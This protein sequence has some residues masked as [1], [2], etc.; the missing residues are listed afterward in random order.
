MNDVKNNEEQKKQDF[1]KEER[2]T[3]SHF[4]AAAS[5]PVPHGVRLF[6]PLCL[7][8]C[9]S[10]LFFQFGRSFLLLPMKLEVPS[11]NE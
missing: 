5:L 3:F 11:K 8:L 10:S 9:H 4:S 6:L 2:K 7:V 1:S